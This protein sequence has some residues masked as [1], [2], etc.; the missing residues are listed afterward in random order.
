VDAA[1]AVDGA[2]KEGQVVGVVDAIAGD[3]VRAS[4]A[5]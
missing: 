1:A 5:G 2:V 3:E 4:V